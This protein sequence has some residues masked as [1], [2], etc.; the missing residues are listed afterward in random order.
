MAIKNFFQTI[1]NGACICLWGTYLSMGHI[2]VY[3]ARICLWGTYLYMGHVS[4][5]E[6]RIC[7]WGTYLSIHAKF[8]VP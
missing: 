3:G 4:V 5:Y 8:I 1:P 7:L 6:A 2:S